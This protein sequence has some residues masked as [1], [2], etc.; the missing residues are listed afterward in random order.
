MH[1]TSES[2]DV[3]RTQFLFNSHELATKRLIINIGIIADD[4]CANYER[5]NKESIENDSFSCAIYG[6]CIIEHT[7]R[8]CLQRFSANF[9]AAAPKTMLIP[10]FHK[11]LTVGTFTFVQDS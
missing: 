6:V 7:R 2:C 5:H 1:L 11:L 10:R 4:Q 8:I 9:V 3:I